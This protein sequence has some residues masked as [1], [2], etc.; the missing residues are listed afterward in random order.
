MEVAIVGLA[1]R[2]TF[3][4]DETVTEARI[5]VCS[6][7]SKAFRAPDAE[8]RLVGSQ[9][10]REAIREAGGLLRQQ[11]RPINDGRAT[12]SYRLRLLDPLLRQA[13]E[14]CRRRTLGVGL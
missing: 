5:A 7:A 6:V 12:A 9:L 10:D 11:A 8:R 13:V 3:S 4:E 2:V 1:A 14:I